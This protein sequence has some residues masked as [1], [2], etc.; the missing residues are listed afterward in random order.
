[1]RIIT[2]GLSTTIQKTISFDRVEKGEVNRSTSYRLDASGKAVNSA[3]VLCQIEPRVATAL[4]P[5]GRETAPFFLELA[6]KDGLPVK[7]VSFPG[8][9]RYCYTLLEPGNATELVVGEPVDPLDA[10]SFADAAV[11][12]EKLLATELVGADA[13]LIA[14]SRPS[15]YPDD[16]YARFSSMARAAGV[17]VMADYHGKDLART[18]AVAVPSIIKINEEEFAGTFGF[19]F[20]IPSEKLADLVARKSAELR[21]V[22]V[23]T[24][25]SR[26]TFA[27]SPDGASFRQ[28]VQA[29][30]AVN[31]IGCGDS[32]SA[33]FLHEWLASRDIA[34]ALAEGTRCATLNAMSQRPGSILDPA[35]PV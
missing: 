2:I 35:N 12:I 29:V 9:V 22:I 21:S 7:W 30:T 20:P 34:S 16:I 25:G 31:P 11:A 15:G 1:M 17:A 8:R 27:G 4:C 33:G 28:P 5:L 19:D 13:L 14:G 18:L 10:P 24:R 32:F 3:R 6:E 26:D 23:V